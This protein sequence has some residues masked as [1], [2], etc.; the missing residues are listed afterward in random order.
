MIRRRQ[1][2]SAGG[3]FVAGSIASLPGTSAQAAEPLAPRDATPTP[4]GPVDGAQAPSPPTTAPAAPRLNFGPPQPF[5]AERLVA[6]ARA[7]SRE[8]HRPPTSDHRAM[9]E[10]IDYDAH[11]RIRYRPEAALFA[12][13]PGR[14]PVTFFHLGRYFQAPVRMHE[15]ESAT[16]TDPFLARE[17]LYD[18]AG[19]EMP[20]DSPARALPRGAGFAGFRVQE[21]R[22]PDPA[23]PL[24]WK[25]N[26]WMAFLGASYFRAVGELYQYG[27]SARGIA[28]D[29][30]APGVAEEFPVFT[31]FWFEP[32]RPEQPDTVVVHALLDGPSLTGAYRFALTRQPRLVTE[33]HCALFMRRDVQRLGI[34]PASSMYWF[35]ETAKPQAV[36]W[37]PEVHDS[38]GLAIWN[39]AGEQLWRPLNNPPRTLTSS[40][41]DRD[42]KGFGLMQ[43]DRAFDHYLDGVAYD[44]RPHLWVE[45][46]DAW[47]P[48]SVQLVEIPTDDEIH[49][50]IVAMWVP[51]A[52]ARAGDALSFRYRLHWSGDA[53]GLAAPPPVLA[54]CVATRQGNGG[55]PGQPRPV[56][57]RK[58]VVEFLGGAL[59]NLPYGT[60]PEAQVET[61]RGSISNVFT[62]PVPNGVAGHWRAQ[63]DIAAS[64]TDP[65]ELRLTLRHA[66]QALSETWLGQ[67]HPG[68]SAR[69]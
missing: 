26:D 12:D 46:L 8:P 36:D 60:R 66:G 22:Q 30:A 51:A 3:A 68:G 49:D 29:V 34:A 10:R 61:S 40:F 65:V 1:L 19:F 27:L 6:F 44:R 58:F 17:I 62:E 53:P 69:G 18:E 15:L 5:S 24:D 50:N 35:S 4:S 14:Y 32:P 41:S 33:V 52:P 54:R 59:V 56:G 37:R 63:F 55:R 23:R 25:T 57:V 2:L 16:G 13:G 67:Y 9:L 45:P 28:I 38:D 20:D 64:G 11:G 47:G 39:G 43:R 48:G 31:A 42:P 21:S 7:L